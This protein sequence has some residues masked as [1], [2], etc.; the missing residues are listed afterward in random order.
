MRPTSQGLPTPRASEDRTVSGTSSTVVRTAGCESWLVASA[1]QRLNVDR[2]QLIGRRLKNVAVVLDLYG[3]AQVLPAR[4]ARNE[5]DRPRVHA[6][7]SAESRHDPRL[8]AYHGLPA[9]GSRRL[10]AD[11][12]Q[13]RGSRRGGPERGGPAGEREGRGC[14]FLSLGHCSL[15]G[16]FPLRAM[17]GPA[18]LPPPPP[19][20]TAHADGLQPQTATWRPEMA[21]P[22]GIRCRIADIASG[23]VPGASR[24]LSPVGATL[25]PPTHHADCSPTLS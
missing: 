2:R 9:A 6:R 1:S 22:G 5:A 14:L 3:L 8:I 15:C 10:V 4:A 25:L 11:R 16:L 18:R 19:G 24:G 12:C 20:K 23:V 13:R 7:C 17:L 21:D